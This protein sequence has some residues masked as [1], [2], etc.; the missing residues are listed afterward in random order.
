MQ[1]INRFQFW[2]FFHRKL[3]TFYGHPHYLSDFNSWGQNN[4]FFLILFFFVS[5]QSPLEHSCVFLVVGPSSCGTWDAASAW[6]WEV[7]HPCPGFEL[8]KSWAAQAEH[9]DL[10][11]QP[12]GWPPKIT[13]VL[14]LPLCLFC[15][16]F[17]IR[18]KCNSFMELKSKPF[19]S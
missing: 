16:V 5:L 3:G 11:T 10:T 1:R 6:P 9:T 17:S 14:I 12:W 18:E 2:L 7:P 8:A 13:F 15:L 19:I 4:F